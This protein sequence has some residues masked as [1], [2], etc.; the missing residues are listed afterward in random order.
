MPCGDGMKGFQALE[1]CLDKADTMV[2]LNYEICNFFFFFSQG[3]WWLKNVT[4]MTC[5][6]HLRLKKKSKLLVSVAKQVVFLDEP[7]TSFKRVPIYWFRK[8][9]ILS[10]EE[11]MHLVKTGLLGHWKE[12]NCFFVCVY[13]CV[14]KGMGEGQFY[15]QC[16]FVPKV[17]TFRK[18]FLFWSHLDE[19]NK[20]NPGGQV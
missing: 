11:P 8:K 3:T 18:D 14:C 17:G 20:Q 6:Q 1:G 13:V 7:D 2:S 15:N 9:K 10:L 12:N 16:L 19:L 5:L 4:Y